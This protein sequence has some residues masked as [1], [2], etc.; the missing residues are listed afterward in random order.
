MR[1]RFISYSFYTLVTAFISL[2]EVSSSA[3]AQDRFAVVIGEHSDLF[4]FGPKGENLGELSAPTVGKSVTVG[5]ASFQVSYGLDSDGHLSA[6]LSPSSGDL[7][8]ILLGRNVD[9]SNGAAVTLTIRTPSRVTIDPGSVGSVTVNS[10][11]VKNLEL[12]EGILRQEPSV[13]APVPRTHTDI[14]PRELPPLA[15][16][17][18]SQEVKPAAPV[19]TNAPPKPTASTSATVTKYYWSEP[20]TPPNGPPPAVGLD[21][22][23]LV[24]LHGSVSLKTADGVIKPAEEGMAIASG[25][26]IITADNAS[27][28]V[29]IGGVNSV[30]LM[31]DCEL[32]ITLKLEGNLRKTVVGLDHGAVF[33][34]I[35]HLVG[36]KEDFEVKTPEGVAIAHGTEILT[37][38]GTLADLHPKMALQQGLARKQLLAWDP[39][40]LGQRQICDVASPV[41]DVGATDD[42]HFFIYCARGKVEC[43]VNGKVVKLVS[44]DTKKVNHAVLPS[45]EGADTDAKKAFQAILEILQPYNFKLNEILDGISK[46]TANPG[47]QA[48]YKNLITVSLG[49]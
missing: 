9:A 5:D 45:Y 24:E 8:F 26:T 3:T 19:G 2:S 12:L 37:Y 30:R 18:A 7:H 41:L 15:P 49:N 22:M 21:E 13:S 40:S 4:I 20:G 29:F 23:K 10:H 44:G 42:S 35:G 27:A 6:I 48:F 28:A 34:R 36:E 14:K 11:S 39:S 43:T 33:S 25:S 1:K 17:P 47:Q 32:T 46:G 16:P 38:R 31:P